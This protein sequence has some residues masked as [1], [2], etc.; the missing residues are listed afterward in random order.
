[1]PPPWLHPASLSELIHRETK[2]DPAQFSPPPPPAA[3]SDS[4]NPGDATRGGAYDGEMRLS[5]PF[6]RDCAASAPAGFLPYHWLEM[7]EA[8]LAHAAD[9]M[10]APAGEVRSL[11]R[12]LVEVLAAKMRASSGQLGGVGG[13][14]LDL[15]GV[16]AV[17]LAENRAFV[18]G[19][20]D[21]ARR[22]GASAEAGRREEEE[23]GGAGFGDG[24]DESDEE[25]GL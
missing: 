4:R 16:G 24:D 23:A 11:L 18:L 6:L 17:E 19:V 1:M 14:F 13:G 7:A 9:D 20:V 10:P 25:M 21:G 15:T 5:P 22:I 12:D 8:L 3:R 2:V